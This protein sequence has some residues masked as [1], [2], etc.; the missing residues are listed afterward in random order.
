VKRPIF[1]FASI[2]SDEPESCSINQTCGSEKKSREKKNSQ[3]KIK[4]KLKD[5][6]WAMMV[7]K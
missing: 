4:K 1:Q 2:L 5:E 3:N 6:I 7:N